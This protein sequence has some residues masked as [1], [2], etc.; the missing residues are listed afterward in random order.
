M[1]KFPELWCQQRYAPWI[2]RGDCALD[3]F[4]PVMIGEVERGPV[5]RQPDLPTNILV[6]LSRFFGRHVNVGP[7]L[8]GPV[9]AGFDDSQVK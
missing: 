8:P 1:N 3:R 9:R 4:V 5:H 7:G 2:G 6:H